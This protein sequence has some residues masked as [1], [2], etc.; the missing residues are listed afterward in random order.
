MDDG[1]AIINIST[2]LTPHVAADSLTCA[3]MKSALEIAT[4]YLVLELKLGPRRIA[5]SSAAPGATETDLFGGAVRGDAAV[6]QYVAQHTAMGR[7]G[8]PDD[9]GNAV[10]ILLVGSGL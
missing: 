5:V 8:R 4:R 1:D 10:A 3:A 7:T 6:N 9:I 2:S